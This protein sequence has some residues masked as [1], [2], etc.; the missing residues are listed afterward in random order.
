[1]NCSLMEHLPNALDQ[2]VL[3]TFFEMKIENCAELKF[4]KFCVWIR[5]KKN[6]SFL[7]RTFFIFLFCKDLLVSYYESIKNH[8]R[9]WC[10]NTQD[11]F[12]RQ[13]QG[14]TDTVLGSYFLRLKDM[15]RLENLMR[16]LSELYALTDCE[17]DYGLIR[18]VAVVSIRKSGAGTSIKFQKHMEFLFD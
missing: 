11:M 6:H 3:G 4:D 18:P 5:C 14:L 7:W 13:F 10:P 17:L 9:N 12:L 15:I 8:I 1:M 16:R 2:E